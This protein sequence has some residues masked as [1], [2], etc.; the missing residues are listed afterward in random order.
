MATQSD[1]LK[2]QSAQLANATQHV[3]QL[4]GQVA[5]QSVQLTTQSAQLANA[6]HHINNNAAQL[7]DLRVNTG[8]SSGKVIARWRYAVGYHFFH[9]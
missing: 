7:Q 3:Q 5:T 2:T 4:Q 8:N 6:S 1:Q 9:R